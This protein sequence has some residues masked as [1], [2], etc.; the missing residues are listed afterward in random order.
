MKLVVFDI[1]VLGFYIFYFWSENM[2]LKSIF[3]YVK[4]LVPVTSITN[5]PV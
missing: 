4:D 1:G 2:L 3:G 5:A